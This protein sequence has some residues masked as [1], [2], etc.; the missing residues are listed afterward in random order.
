MTDS[1]KRFRF[2][3]SRA[4]KSPTGKHLFRI[5]IAA[6]CWPCLQGPFVQLFVGFLLIDAWFGLESYKKEPKS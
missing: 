1:S 6:G 3:M 5:G 4:K 2:M